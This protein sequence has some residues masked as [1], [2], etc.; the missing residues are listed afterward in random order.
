MKERRA[1]C[2]NIRRMPCGINR[3]EERIP[4]RASS[5]TSLSLRRRSES[6]GCGTVF[7]EWINWRIK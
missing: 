2:C 6:Y 4:K 7:I 5:G 1:G 3:R